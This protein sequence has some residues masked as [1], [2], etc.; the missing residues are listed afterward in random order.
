MV[1]GG[2][3]VEGGSEMNGRGHIV[4]QTDIDTGQSVVAYRL[5]GVDRE[6]VHVYSST[7]YM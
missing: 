6:H 3:G 5:E 2:L 7:I 1:E 4:T